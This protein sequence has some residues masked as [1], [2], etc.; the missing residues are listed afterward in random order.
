MAASANYS[1][2]L[3]KLA[4]YNTIAW[5]V[6]S[7]VS[8]VRADDATFVP[9]NRLVIELQRTIANAQLESE[10]PPF[11]IIQKKHLKLK[12]DNEAAA[13]GGVTFTVPILKHG[14]D[15]AVSAK[16]TTGTLLEIDLIP[17]E[18][19]VVGGEERIN[20]S[21]LVKSLKATFGTING[22][23][24]S[25]IKYTETW[26]LQADAEGN[27]NFVIAKANAKMSLEYLQEIS[28]DLCQTKDKQ[29]CVH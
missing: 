8:P 28:F 3:R 15:G 17:A 26:V 13:S 16:S 25:S 18:Q 1:Y 22:L 19:I 9:L 2:G 4:L 27:V 5:F 11:F 7:S 6:L 12:G 10:T 14:V 29:T 21:E 23:L 20:F 24:A